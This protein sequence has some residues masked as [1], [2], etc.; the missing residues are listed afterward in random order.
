MEQYKKK[1]YKHIFSG[2]MAYEDCSHAFYNIHGYEFEAKPSDT[3]NFNPLWILGK[4]EIEHGLY[5]RLIKQ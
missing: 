5:W 2:L 3:I 4:N 1:V